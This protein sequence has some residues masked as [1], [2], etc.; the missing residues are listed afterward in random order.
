MKLK[1][2]QFGEIEF[3]D[4]SVIEFQEGL[5]GFEELTKFVL[6]P[7][8][9]GFLKWLTSVDQPEIIF[10]LFSINALQEEQNSVNDYE[11]F[12]IVKLD[13]IPEDIT[14]N[15]KAPVFIDHN[16]KKGYQRIIDNEEYPVNYPL[17]VNN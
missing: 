12:G 4:N 3:D 7:E 10:P 14:I 5:L 2:E 17:F 6:I 15:L 8:E 9:D 16:K 13:K 1:N 11:P